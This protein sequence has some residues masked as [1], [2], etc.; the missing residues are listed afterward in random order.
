[1]LANKLL[2]TS[3]SKLPE[4][5]FF[6]SMSAGA[7]IDTDTAYD[8]TTGNIV[9]CLSY[10]NNTYVYAVKA[11]GELSWQKIIVSTNNT[12]V[13][14]ITVNSS[15]DVFV[16]YTL[17][18]TPTSVEIVRLSSS[19]TYV[20]S[21]RV[22]DSV[23][24]ATAIERSK[25]FISDMSGNTYL[26]CTISTSP[27]RA[28]LFKFSSSGSLVWGL[29]AYD[30]VAVSP[31][32][33]SIESSG[34]LLFT[35]FKTTSGARN[36][37]YRVNPSSSIVG[38]YGLSITSG[39]NGRVVPYSDGSVYLVG[40][41]NSGAGIGFV[42]YNSSFTSPIYQ[43]LSTLNTT[44]TAVSVIGDKIVF[45]T[46]ANQIAIANTDLSTISLKSSASSVVTHTQRQLLSANGKMLLSGV[47]RTTGAYN[48]AFVSRLDLSNINGDYGVSKFTIADTASTWTSGTPPSSDT[49]TSTAGSYTPT[50]SSSSPSVSNS[51]LTPQL[52]LKV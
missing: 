2:Q 22:S 19:G 20:S 3:L 43:R 12:S 9:S 6:Q 36:F 38:S 23:N 13:P 40:Y 5:L 46:A 32:N 15:G 10:L 44:T 1:M 50:A 47:A 31:L 16:A 51:S 34:D 49:V 25:N 48:D 11:S 17:A 14:R 24:L 37:I 28:A 30:S 39:S 8:S 27:A 26:T 4:N 42:K 45:S 41:N 21:V 7:N 18:T 33:I 29:Q 35:V 52:F